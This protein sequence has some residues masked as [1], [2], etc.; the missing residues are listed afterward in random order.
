MTLYFYYIHAHV[1]RYGRIKKD[2]SELKLKLYTSNNYSLPTPYSCY[3][4]LPTTYRTKQDSAELL[5]EFTQKDKAALLLLDM[6]TSVPLR[7]P[8]CTSAR[9]CAPLPHYYLTTLLSHHTPQ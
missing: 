8:S 2:A 7:A 9:P 5:K 4:L 1:R 3:L 6:H